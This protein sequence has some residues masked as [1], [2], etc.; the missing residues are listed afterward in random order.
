MKK[1]RGTLIT[2]TAIGVAVKVICS[3]KNRFSV[4][5]T[6]SQ[7]ELLADISDENIIFH[8]DVKIY[9]DGKIIN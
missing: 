7:D 3:N 2:L 1:V 4:T 6:N 5:V 9:I 8:D